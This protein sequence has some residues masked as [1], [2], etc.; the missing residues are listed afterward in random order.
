MS[1]VDWVSKFEEFLIENN[2]YSQFVTKLFEWH[3]KSLSEYIND[4]IYKQELVLRAFPFNSVF[5]QNLH[6]IWTETFTKVLRDNEC[7][8][9]NNSV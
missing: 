1:K 3:K 9:I 8:K 7:N 4:S 2:C 5:W 6:F